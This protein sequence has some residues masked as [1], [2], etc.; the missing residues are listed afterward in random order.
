MGTIFYSWQVD[1][2][3]IN[4]RNFIERALHSAIDRMKADIEL[5]ESLRDGLELDK[6]T[7]NVP[8][9]PSIFDTI[10]Q[11]IASATIFVPDLT[12]V[13]QREK[14][15]PTSN[16]NVLIEYGYALHKPGPFRILAVMNDLYG[17]PTN[18]TIPFN[19]VHRRFPI[20]YTLAEDAN[21]EERKAE[22]KSLTA[23]FENALRAIDR[24]SVV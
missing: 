14:G 21:D 1:R 18:L 15:T 19:Q 11:K 24:K 7:K 6:D 3:K 23:K 20:T 2:P 4:C 13:G 9:S 10:M 17:E 8:G 12:F 22:K 5:E 16:P